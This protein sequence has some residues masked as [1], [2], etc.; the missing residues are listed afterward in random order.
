MNSRLIHSSHNEYHEF[1][2][3][4]KVRMI[5]PEDAWYSWLWIVFLSF[6]C[7][8]VI[9]LVPNSFNSKLMNLKEFEV[10]INVFLL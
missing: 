10:P 3:A 8:Q 6:K 4:S 5:A 9:K 7:G 2:I 1:H